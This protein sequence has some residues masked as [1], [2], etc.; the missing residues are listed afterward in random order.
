MLY[1]KFFTANTHCSSFRYVNTLRHQ[2]PEGYNGVGA[3]SDLLK[4][5]ALTEELALEVGFVAREEIFHP[6]KGFD[7]PLAPCLRVLRDY[8]FVGKM[9]PVARKEIKEM[10]K[11]FSRI[12][13]LSSA[14]VNYCRYLQSLNGKQVD[15]KST[16]TVIAVLVTIF[17]DLHDFITDAHVMYQLPR[18][19]TNIAIKKIVEPYGGGPM[20]NFIL[21][22]FGTLSIA[23]SKSRFHKY[24][25][26][27]KSKVGRLK[28]LL[29]PRDDNLKVIWGKTPLKSAAPELKG[30][31]E[32]SNKGLVT[33][34]A[35]K[36]FIEDYLKNSTHSY[37]K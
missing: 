25:R 13:N 24:A 26:K 3:N 2:Y 20:K 16:G 11:E 27:L 33:W 6:N 29:G 12:F 1:T 30:L 9:T 23:S 35:S 37:E 4:L 36:R 18:D 28:E 17:M 31:Y 8:L 14:V 19:R 7:Q 22:M 5:S 34:A 15:P 32:L 10:G 21:T